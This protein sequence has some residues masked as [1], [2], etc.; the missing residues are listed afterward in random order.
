MSTWNVARTTRIPFP[1][2][3]PGALA[4]LALA[5]CSAPRVA[6]EPGPW[7]PRIVAIGGIGMRPAELDAAALEALGSEDL[8]WTHHGEESVCRGVELAKVLVHCGLDAGTSGPGADPHEKHLGW[9]RVVVATA[10]DGFQAV[11]SSAELM[12]EIGP[13][14]AFLAWSKDGA[15]LDDGEG[16]LRLLVRSDRKGSRSLRQVARLDVRSTCD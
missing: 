5:A 9:R 12:P 10:A 3:C 13:T 8:R 4:A 15:A 14:P 7:V 2:H 11:F 6:A 16:P 1:K